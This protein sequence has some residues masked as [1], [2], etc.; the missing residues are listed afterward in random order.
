M[1][2]SQ[3]I[4]RWVA[5]A[6]AERPILC[7]T[8]STCSYHQPEAEGRSRERLIYLSIEKFGGKR[9]V[10]DVESVEPSLQQD[11]VFRGMLRVLITCSTAA[12]QCLTCLHNAYH[13]WAQ[14]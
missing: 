11:T 13:E 1:R 9:Y 10:A 3:F 14:C 2:V 7:R 12:P 6:Q 8:T 5:A 4:L